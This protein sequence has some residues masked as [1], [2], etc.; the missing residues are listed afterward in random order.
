MVGRKILSFCG[1]RLERYSEEEKSSLNSK[2][3]ILAV[4]YSEPR[5]DERLLLVPYGSM[6]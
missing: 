6:N 2:Y 3:V 5:F 4:V 1:N